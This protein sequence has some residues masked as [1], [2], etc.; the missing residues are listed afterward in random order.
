MWLDKQN[1]NADHQYS[2]RALPRSSLNQHLLVRDDYP[3]VV[4]A[5]SSA[6]EHVTCQIPHCAPEIMVQW[7]KNDL[8]T[9]VQTV[10]DGSIVFTT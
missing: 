8:Q 1:M 4:H 3:E 5:E 2:E 7:A 6:A 10:S 9:S